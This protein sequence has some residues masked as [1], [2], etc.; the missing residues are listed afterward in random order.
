MRTLAA[1]CLHYGA[2]YLGYAIRSVLA[3]VDEV[4]VFYSGTPSHGRGTDA[5]LPESE[6]EGRLKY[7]AF[8]AAGPKCTWITGRWGTEG[9]HRDAMETYARDSGYDRMLVLDAD[10]VWPEALLHHLKTSFSIG[11]SWTLP[12]VHL[13]QG[14]DRVCRDACQPQRVVFPQAVGV[15]NV[16]HLPSDLPPIYHFGYAISDELMAYKWKIHG[17]FD[18]LRKGWMEEKWLARATEDVHPTNERGF[19]NARPFDRNL[20]PHVM[21]SHPRWKP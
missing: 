2:E 17:H 20:L 6:A 11:R 19:W 7:I 16:I 13:W 10:E 5:K 4:A 9:A 8:D 18:E 3:H 15:R 21:R 12:M 1:C 14:F